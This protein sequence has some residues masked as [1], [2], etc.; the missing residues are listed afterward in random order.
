MAVASCTLKAPSKAP[1]SST[2]QI[3]KV[4]G[5][6]LS[7]RS[8]GSKCVSRVDHI[9]D[10][11]AKGHGRS[12]QQQSS[13]RPV[14]FQTWKCLSDIWKGQW[15]RLKW[16]TLKS[17]QSLADAQG[18]VNKSAKLGHGCQC[19]LLLHR[20]V[21]LQR[22]QIIITFVYSSALGWARSLLN[23]TPLGSERQGPIH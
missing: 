11:G 18:E 9:A 14:A 19:N 8:W 13:M 2:G 5:T 20:L 1:N 3:N 16:E 15:Y 7:C 4:Q 23:K 12:T 21:T 6:V 17:G 10:R 22:V